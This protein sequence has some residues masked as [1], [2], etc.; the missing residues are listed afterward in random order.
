MVHGPASI[1]GRGYCIYCRNTGVRLTDEHFLP[2]SLG[3]SHVI[4]DASCDSCA[5]ITKRFEQDVARGM[6]G[7]ARISYNAPTRKKR[8]RPT[9]IKLKDPNNPERLLKVPY[10]DYPAPMIFYRMQKAGFLLGVPDHFELWKSWQLVAVSDTDKN[11]AFEK[12]FGVKLTAKFKHVPDS[13]SR[14]LLKIGYGQILWSLDPTDFRPFC[15]PYILGERPHPDHLVGGSFDIPE[16]ELGMG[17]RCDTIAFGSADRLLLIAEIRLFANNSTPV[18]HAVIGEVAGVEKVA[19]VFGK[20][21][22]TPTQVSLIPET[23]L[24]SHDAHWMPTVWPL[25]QVA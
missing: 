1:P 14:L 8:D 18:Y 12:K 25:P 13:F 7:D 19:E 24:P 16:P 6:W 9:H 4:K 21:D 23:G 2:Y 17:Y 5:N 11:N 10:A 20:L 22:G 15:I 3:G